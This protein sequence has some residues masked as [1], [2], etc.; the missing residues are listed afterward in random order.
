MFYVVRE[1]QKL[2]GPDKQIKGIG[3]SWPDMIIDNVIV[4][5]DTGKTFS[6][7]IKTE[8]QEQR[9]SEKAQRKTNWNREEWSR[10][11]YWSEFNKLGR[12][13]ER[14]EAEFGIPI[15]ATNDGNITAFWAG[16]ERAAQ[17]QDKIKVRGP[18][19]LLARPLGLIARLSTFKKSLFKGI[20]GVALG[21]SPG[22]GYM[23]IRGRLTS[24]FLRASNVVITSDRLPGTENKNTGI[25]DAAQKHLAQTATFR[26]CE[27]K[28][29]TLVDPTKAGKLEE[30]SLMTDPTRDDY[31]EDAVEIFRHLGRHFGVFLH[32]I[33]PGFGVQFPDELLLTG[34]ITRVK[35]RDKATGVE[36]DVL[37]G[38]VFFESLKEA[39][40]TEFKEL[41]SLK[42]I[43]PEEIVPDDKLRRFAQAYGTIYLVN[44]KIQ[45]SS[46]L[47][48]DKTSASRATL[49]RLGIFT[50]SSL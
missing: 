3:L 41:K 34:R 24:M 16:V 8:D 18:V 32:T 10:E 5:G 36:H 19:S 45:S 17:I 2:V 1:V 42:I 9:A 4:G 20:L 50:A 31:N 13:V 11:D 26:L 33:R 40:D 47:I 49:M 44:Q 21:T 7:G 23:S 12:L 43:F 28:G 46:P 39:I 25:L 48:V 14:L 38:K 37:S 30:L 15:A 27:E 6:L 29:I 35:I 22:A